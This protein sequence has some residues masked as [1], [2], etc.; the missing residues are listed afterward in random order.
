MSFGSLWLFHYTLKKPNIHKISKWNFA[1]WLWGLVRVETLNQRNRETESDGDIPKQKKVGRFH[2]RH[3]SCAAIGISERFL[4]DFPPLWNSKNGWRREGRGS[5]CCVGRVHEGRGVTQR[6]PKRKKGYRVTIGTL[7]QNAGSKLDFQGAY[8]RD[9]QN[10]LPFLRSL[11]KNVPLEN[12]PIE[13]HLSIQDTVQFRKCFILMTDSPRTLFIGATSAHQAIFGWKL[14][15]DM[16]EWWIL[17]RV[18][19]RLLK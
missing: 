1:L 2:A 14:A 3:V 7:F 17:C 9:S 15:T 13:R 19:N 6:T 12:L 10:L 8:F 11:L 5:R 4:V 18:L 16:H